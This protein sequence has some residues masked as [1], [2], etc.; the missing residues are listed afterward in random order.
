MPR[1]RRAPGAVLLSAVLHVAL[2][3][4][5][6]RK[7]VA[8]PIHDAISVEVF[9]VAPAP[10]ARAPGAGRPAAP[11]AAP[12]AAVRRPRA[13]ESAAAPERT[14]A[15]AAPAADGLLRMRSHRV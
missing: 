4:L 1:S 2:M 15:P 9:S 13:V 8:P 14:A 12:G 7:P 10:A 3:A 6:A 11:P 5:I